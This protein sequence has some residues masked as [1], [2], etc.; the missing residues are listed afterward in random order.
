MDGGD[1]GLGK[2][3][4]SVVDTPTLVDLPLLAGRPA[5]EL[6]DVGT[7][8]EGLLSGAVQEGDP[9]P[10]V[11]GQGIHHLHEPLPHRLVEGVQLVRA[12]QGDDG[13]PVVPDVHQHR[14]FAHE[15]LQS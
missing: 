13:D 15:S 1:D 4:Q 3:R 7:R 5:R 8:H 9:D 2:S 11:G 6:A 14:V 12:V 10:V